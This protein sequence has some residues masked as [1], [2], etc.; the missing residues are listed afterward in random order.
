M[1]P[2]PGRC[3]NPQFLQ[4]EL[5]YTVFVIIFRYITTIQKI[6]LKLNE[7]KNAAN[8]DVS[9]WSKLFLLKQRVG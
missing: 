6:C 4:W 7:D 3:G 5:K 9:A 1:F 2:Y 8:F